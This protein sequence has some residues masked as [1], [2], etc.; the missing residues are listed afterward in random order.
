MTYLISRWILQHLRIHFGEQ[1]FQV[2][3][4]Q[5]Q[6]LLENVAVATVLWLICYWMYRRQVFLRI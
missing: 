5:Y 4:A 3:G 2:F 6:P 1:P